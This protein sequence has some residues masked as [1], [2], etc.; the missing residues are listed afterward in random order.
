[1]T[2]VRTPATQQLRTHFALERARV[3]LRLARSGNLRDAVEAA[4]ESARLDPS[5]PHPHVIAAKI[6]FWRGD[7]QESERALGFATRLG[8][9]TS[10]AGAMQWAIDEFR[11]RLRREDEA[12][13]YSRAL[14]H[15]QGQRV[16]SILCHGLDWFTDARLTAFV[17]LAL[18]FVML[19]FGT[20]Q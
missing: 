16:R 2:P 10:D 13:E 7:L 11:T 20:L 17:F 15:H 9:A 1:M 12:R 19:Q 4:E 14:W 5:L 3:A 18:L 6:W 8:L